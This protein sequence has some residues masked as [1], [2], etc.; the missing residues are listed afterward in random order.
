MTSDCPVPVPWHC[1]T[2]QAGEGALENTAGDGGHGGDGKATGSRLST[3]ARL[4]G[5]LPIALPALGPGSV[6]DLVV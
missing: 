6:A 5:N 2:P 4:K 1:R 3:L